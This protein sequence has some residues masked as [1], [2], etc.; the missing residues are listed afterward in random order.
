VNDL[1]FILACFL[2]LAVWARPE[3]RDGVPSSSLSAP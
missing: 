1:T 2:H 3:G